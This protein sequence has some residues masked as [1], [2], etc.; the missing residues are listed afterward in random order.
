M[1]APY[2]PIIYIRGFAMTENE[3]EQTMSDPF[4]G[5]N[6]GSTLYRAHVNRDKPPHR[7]IFES[8]V[9]R[10]RSDFHYRDTYEFGMDLADP[11]HT[12][13]HMHARSIII[14]R[15]YDEATP[16]FGLA[17]EEKIEHF[18]QGLSDLILRVRD[19]IC[20]NPE[21]NT[22]PQDFRCYLV[23]HSM[24][25][26]IC[27][28]FLQNTTLGCHQARQCVDKVFTYATPH[29]GIDFLGIKVPYWLAAADIN[30][31]SPARMAEYLGLESLYKK[32]RRVDWLDRH[33]FPIDRF[34]CMVGTNRSDYDA[35]MGLARTFSGPGS[36][37]LVR[38]ENASVWRYDPTNNAIQ[39]C[40][41]AYCYRAHSGYYG[42]VNSVE[43]Y[44]NL[45]RFLFGQIRVDV[46]FDVDEVR[47]PSQQHHSNSEAVLDIDALY[48]FEIKVSTRG[49]KW[50][51]SRRCVE[52]DSV[53]CRTYKELT[54]NNNSVYLS[55]FYLGEQ[56]RV[57]PEAKM[58]AVSIQ[59]GVLASEYRYNQPIFDT[60]FEGRHLLQD[61]LLLECDCPGQ[62]DRQLAIKTT[63]RQEQNTQS[64]SWQ[65][66]AP[67]HI[68]LDV[69]D[70]DRLLI[71]GQLHLVIR[72]WQTV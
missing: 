5:F 24:G 66:Q 51:L 27:R 11:Q 72:Q 21:N 23:A 47:L 64:W 1:R 67:I 29:N 6:T 31:F 48:Q 56:W 33:S 4:Y 38:Q 50:F 44:Q 35:A 68:K 9:I 52:E 59:I 45:V 3:L 40:P 16:L 12:L 42:I 65:P 8:P 28:A 19:K 53:A 69:P 25:G 63:W 36:D 37:G 26:L 10:L 41:T 13:E 60:H 49:S 70:S 39:P 20:N 30:N 55:S 15:Y 32:T 62:F 71:Q 61:S 54:S 18:A 22:Q 46:W 34:F 14:Y 17:Q 57:V 43:A 2:Y 7:Y 58:L